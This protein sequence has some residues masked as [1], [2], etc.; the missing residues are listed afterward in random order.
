M[1]SINWGK[2]A[3][4]RTWV[5]V[6]VGLTGL[7]VAAWMWAVPAGVAVGSAACILL[8]YLTDEA[9]SERRRT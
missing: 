6:L 5:L 8:A 7:T 9:P 3:A 1:S 4:I 2:L